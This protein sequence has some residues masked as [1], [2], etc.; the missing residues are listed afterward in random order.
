MAEKTYRKA[1][2]EITN[3][4]NLSCSFCPGTNRKKSF[5]TAG[6]FE[7]IADE[8]LPF[9]D[10]IYLHLMGEPLLHPQLGEILGMAKSKGLKVIV[11]TNGTLL[12]KAGETLISSGALFKVNISLQSYVGNLSD[13]NENPDE[14]F[15][16]VFD[17]AE[18]SAESGI[19]TV[20]RLWNGGELGKNR[21]ND[22]IFNRIRERFP[23]EYDKDYRGFRLRRLLFLE[24]GEAFEWSMSDGRENESVTCFALR[25][26]FGILCDGTVV[27]CCLDRDGSLALGNVFDTPLADILSSERTVRFRESLDRHIPPSELCRHCGF[28]KTLFGK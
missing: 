11:T 8:V 5:M 10:F 15:D 9:T 24:Y 1:Y 25:D 26:Q 4:C 3:V 6:E 7:K 12:G 22:R 28:A 2:I 27:P 17:F 21:Y 13:G 19:I 18:K 20:M 23:G 16:S 14:Y